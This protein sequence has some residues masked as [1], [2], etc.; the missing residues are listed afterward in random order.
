MKLLLL[1]TDGNL[2]LLRSFLQKDS[3]VDCTEEKIVDASGYDLLIS[4]GYRHLMSA[5]VLGSCRR[6]PVNIHISYLPY[7]RGSDPNF[8]AWFDGTPHGVSVHHIDEG[9]DTGDLLV[10][11]R[12]FFA[13]NTT[14]KESYD[15]LARTA[16]ALFRRHWRVVADGTYR[17][18]PQRGRGTTHLFKDLPSFEGGWGQTIREIRD[19]LERK[20]KA[21]CRQKSLDNLAGTT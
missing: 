4:F 19:Q 1:G 20:P 17:T 13:E 6:V 12:C 9:L 18:F 3:D 7:N 21:R 2:S 5:A 15:A 16:A 14:L 8:W 11:Q 10:R